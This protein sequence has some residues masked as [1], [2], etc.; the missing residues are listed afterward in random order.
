MFI[1]INKI[2]QILKTETGSVPANFKIVNAPGKG[3][4]KIATGEDLIC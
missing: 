1:K 4:K 3:R 2:V